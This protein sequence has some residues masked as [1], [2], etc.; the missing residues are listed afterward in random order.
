MAKDFRRFSPVAAETLFVVCN[1]GT[2][3]K[4]QSV[5][6][7]EYEKSPI[8][9]NRALRRK[10]TISDKTVFKFQVI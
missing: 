5:L 6:Q 7:A 1:A 2:E 4:R 9:E 10:A 3:W 8:R